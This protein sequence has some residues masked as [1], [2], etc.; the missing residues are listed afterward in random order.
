MCSTFMYLYYV[1]ITI[2]TFITT[3]ASFLPI[4]TEETT[5]LFHCLNRIGPIIID[6]L[7]SVPLPET[8]QH[9]YLL[10]D[11]TTQPDV[12]L[13]IS[14]LDEGMRSEEHTSE[15]QSRP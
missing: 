11:Q 1:L 2:S 14:W 15:L 10:V 5:A 8:P 9:A 4:I 3:M 6:V 12:G 13:V 7:N